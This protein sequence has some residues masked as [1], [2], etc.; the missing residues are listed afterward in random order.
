MVGYGGVKDVKECRGVERG[1]V[2]LVVCAVDVGM[3]CSDMFYSGERAFCVFGGDLDRLDLW[4][5]FFGLL[6]GDRV[7]VRGVGMIV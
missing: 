1:E 2:R 7:V 5:M 3:R 4:G 6:D